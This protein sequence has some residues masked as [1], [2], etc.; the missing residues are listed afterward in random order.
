MDIL[1]HMSSK[2]NTLT[3]RAEKEEKEK[4]AMKKEL[5]SLREE[6]RKS[7]NRPRRDP[8]DVTCY[9]CG[10][11]GHFANACVSV[12]GNAANP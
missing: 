5:N 10:K 4:E 9:R 8:K 7:K 3:L 2:L 12:Q 6:M 11:I 1:C